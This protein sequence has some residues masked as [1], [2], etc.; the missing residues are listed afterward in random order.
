MGIEFGRNLA[1]LFSVK[2]GHDERIFLLTMFRSVVFFGIPMLL[3]KKLSVSLIV[4]SGRIALI[5]CITCGT[6]GGM[7]SSCVNLHS[8]VAGSL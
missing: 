4:P 7:V 1:M 2:K 5:R 8:L 6:S 3:Y